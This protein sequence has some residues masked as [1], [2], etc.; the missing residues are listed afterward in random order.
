MLLESTKTSPFLVIPTHLTDFVRDTTDIDDVEEESSEPLP[1]VPVKRAKA[2]LTLLGIFTEQ[3][4]NMDDKQYS[5]VNVI[6]N[7]ID[8]SMFKSHTKSK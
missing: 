1:R 2:V 6:G 5:A 7:H 8:N 4:S 3:Y